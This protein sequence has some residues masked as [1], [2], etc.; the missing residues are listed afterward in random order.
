MWSTIVKPEKF[1][2][3]VVKTAAFRQ[4]RECGSNSISSFAKPQPGL[5]YETQSSRSITSYLLWPRVPESFKSIYFLLACALGFTFYRPHPSALIIALIFWVALEPLAYQARYAWNDLRDADDDQRHPA[6]EQRRRIPK[7]SDAE[8]CRTNLQAVTIMV[9]VRIILAFAVTVWFIRPLPARIGGLV[10]LAA[11]IMQA[12]IYEAT[13]LITKRPGR[14]D[15]QRP[16][17][18]EYCTYVLVGIGY[19]I[20][21]ASGL[22]FGSGYAASPALLI[23]LFAFLSLM[24]TAN[25]MAVWMLEGSTLNTA[26]HENGKSAIIKSHASS[27]WCI[28]WRW[29][30]TKN[31]VLAQR[32]KSV[33]WLE[34]RDPLLSPWFIAHILAA[35]MAGIAGMLLW[36]TISPKNITWSLYVLVAVGAVSVMFTLARL[37]VQK[38]WHV[39]LG[40][41]LVLLIATA[42]PHHDAGAVFLVTPF[43]LLVVVYLGTRSSSYE[44]IA[45]GIAGVGQ[46][47]GVAAQNW[48]MDTLKWTLRNTV[49]S[50]FI[51]QKMQAR[52][53]A[54]KSML[55]ERYKGHVRPRW[56][57]QF[58][59]A[60][61]GVWT[62]FAAPTLTLLAA[63]IKQIDEVNPSRLGPTGLV[64]LIL[65]LGA[66]TA[67]ASNIVAGMLSDQTRGEFGRRRPYIL[68][69]ALGGAIAL[70]ALGSAS[71]WWEVLI[72]W[73]AAQMSLNAMIAGILAL[74]PDK[75]PAADRAKVT[76]IFSASQ[77][78]GAVLG[79]AIAGLFPQ[80]AIVSWTI[81]AVLVVVLAI[82]LLIGADER[83]LQTGQNSKRTKLTRV[84]LGSVF[85][86]FRRQVFDDRNMRLAFSTRFLFQCAITV[87]ETYLLYYLD[88]NISFMDKSSSLAIL[89][90]VLGLSLAS[91]ALLFGWKGDTRRPLPRYVA[92]AG[93]VVATGATLLGLV[94]VLKPTGVVAWPAITVAAIVLG[95]GFGLFAPSD[96]D[97]NTRILPMPQ[98][99]GA[100]LGFLNGASTL[101]QVAGP[102]ISLFA[103][104]ASSTYALPYFAMAFL[105]L[106]GSFVARRIDLNRQE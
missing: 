86:E 16:R 82:P 22:W 73:C 103:A 58:A 6:A 66:A 15:L 88:V 28:F 89:T 31:T 62:C 83:P 32:A 64:P 94:A 70:I 25:A 38:G 46:R 23:G 27:L 53:D 91:T 55:D 7:A 92:L 10:I 4:E 29:E 11:L 69:G 47:I 13:R 84:K 39:G 9:L 101:P 8:E 79:A 2:A 35:A 21:A 80:R 97:I 102:V 100:H 87:G 33:P 71:I 5:G 26:T 42:V 51:S 3:K 60:S 72:L 68:G 93:W 95:V 40:I 74:V 98:H 77:I 30:K 90:A 99:H 20:R 49:F 50:L 17:I 52:I 36:N 59:L 75:I 65:S 18:P 43:I 41:P 48:L 104:S 24:G 96:L 1:I 78:A 105:A 14:A 19:G 76:S 67:F 61:I 37:P 106:I 44:T 85:A 45:S 57:L 34:L 56:L 63:K 54:R 81:V 12:I